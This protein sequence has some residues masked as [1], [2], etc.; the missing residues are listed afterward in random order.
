MKRERESEKERKA[1][2]VKC[3][4]MTRGER[5]KEVRD[6]EGKREREI[7]RVGGEGE[8]REKGTHKNVQENRGYLRCSPEWSL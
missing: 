7:G 1:G 8:E 3:R 4:I 2:K 6:E 5:K